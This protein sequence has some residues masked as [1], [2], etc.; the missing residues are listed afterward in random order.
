MLYLK[1]IKL[2]LVNTGKIKTYFFYALE[3]LH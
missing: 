1:K 2:N 3:K